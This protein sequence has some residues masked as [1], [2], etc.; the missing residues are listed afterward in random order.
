MGEPAAHPQELSPGLSGP[1]ADAAVLGS[2]ARFRV[3]GTL[4]IE[5]QRSR[6]ETPSTTRC[7]GAVGQLLAG[8]EPRAAS[9]AGS[10]SRAQ[11]L[12]G[13]HHLGAR[14]RCTLH[15]TSSKRTPSQQPG[16][17]RSVQQPNPSATPHP[18]LYLQPGSGARRGPF[19]IKDGRHPLWAGRAH[20]EGRHT[21]RRLG[22]RSCRYTCRSRSPVAREL[23][24]SSVLSRSRRVCT[25]RSSVCRGGRHS[26]PHLPAGRGLG[27]SAGSRHA[28]ILLARSRPHSPGGRRG[29]LDAGRETDVRT[30]ALPPSRASA[31]SSG[32]ARVLGTPEACG[33]PPPS[34][35]RLG[36]PHLVVELDLVETLD[37][38][39][40]WPGA[41]GSVLHN[42]ALG[43]TRAGG[44]RGPFPP[45][46]AGV[47]GAP[48]L[49]LL[50]RPLRGPLCTF[51]SGPSSSWNVLLASCPLLPISLVLGASCPL[52]SRPQGQAWR[53]L[54]SRGPPDLPARASTWNGS[55]WGHFFSC[56]L[57]KP[58][59]LLGAQIQTPGTG[60]G[61]GEAPPHSRSH[62]GSH[63]RAPIM[64]TSVG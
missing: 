4:L 27:P 30:P 28:Q 51:H 5:L 21:R 33:G 58:R 32:Q 26:D 25:S 15:P 52:V 17:P 22:L 50:P 56:F 19:S 2:R 8:E 40:G 64:G 24:S 20:L 11:C 13:G 49:H 54:L 7:G 1:R 48:V 23:A 31:A 37:T 36:G 63:P 12:A 53:P 57:G 34:L 47:P 39:V 38:E 62:A 59:Q 42:H 60:L 6:A 44:W 14:K 18:P 35:A 55:C 29:W 46:P 61:G 9:R 10:R 45:P 16:A 43:G 3:Q 41:L